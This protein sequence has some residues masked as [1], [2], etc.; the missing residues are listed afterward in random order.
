MLVIAVVC[1]RHS[2]IGLLAEFSVLAVAIA[3]FGAIR[4]SPQGEGFQVSPSYIP[5]RPGP[6][7]VSSSA[8]GSYL[9]FLSGNQ[10]VV[11]A[12]TGSY[13]LVTVGSQEQPQ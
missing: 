13:C 4:A 6:E 2:W 9:Q 5:P 1:G 3:S 12:V 10:G 7:Y 8:T 11:L